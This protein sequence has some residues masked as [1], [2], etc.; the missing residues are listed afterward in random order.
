M[1]QAGRRIP[2]RQGSARPDDRRV[3]ARRGHALHGV[4]PGR[5]IGPEVSQVLPEQQREYGEPAGNHDPPRGLEIHL[6][7]NSGRLT[8]R[9][10][11]RGRAHQADQPVRNVKSLY[12][13]GPAELVD[14]RGV[15]VCRAPL[16]QRCR[17]RAR[18]RIGERHDPENHL[19]P[20]VLKAAKGNGRTSR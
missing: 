6:L 2:E 19:I 8:T 4:H 7:L 14:V 16:L 20:L 5:G 17:G 11:N 15:P 3:P 1:R 9:T 13:G 12:R 10:H 18:P